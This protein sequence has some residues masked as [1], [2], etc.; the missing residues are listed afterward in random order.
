MIRRVRTDGDVPDTGALVRRFTDDL[1]GSTALSLSTKVA[2][3]VTDAQIEARERVRTQLL[4]QET[5]NAAGPFDEADEIGK[6]LGNA[7]DD[8]FKSSKYGPKDSRLSIFRRRKD[9]KIDAELQIRQSAPKDFGEVKDLVDG[10]SEDWKTSHKAVYR[11]FTRVC[12][13][14]DA[15]DGLLKIIPSQNT[16]VAVVSGS[17]SVIVEAS[18][19]HAEIAENLTNATANL[20]ERAAVCSQLLE[21]IRDQS[22]QKQLGEIYKRLFLFILNAIEWFK[23]SSMSRFWDSFNKAVKE[24]HEE[25][26]KAINT[27]INVLIEKSGVAQLARIEEARLT[28]NIIE[29]KVDNLKEDVVPWLANIDANL[30]TLVEHRRMENPWE[31]PL[32]LLQVGKI[33]GGLLKD[34]CVS[35][36]RDLID[37]QVQETL[38]VRA[39]TPEPSPGSM[40]AITQEGDPK[41]LLLSREAAALHLENLRAFVYG[42]DGLKLAQENRTLLGDVNVVI[43]L[44]RWIEGGL[45]RSERLWIE[46]PFEFHEDTVAKAATLSVI[47]VAAKSGAPFIS[48]IC[49][50][51]RP[52]QISRSQT[53]ETAGLLSVVYSLIFQLLQFRPQHDGFALNPGVPESLDE[54]VKSWDT[55]LRML[56]SLLENT[57]AVRYCIIHGLSLLESSASMKLCKELLSVLISHSSVSKVPFSILFTTSGQSRALAESTSREER[58]VSD[59]SAKRGRGYDLNVRNA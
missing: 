41:E 57:K 17:L 26:E 47:S 21:V 13:T 33:M 1:D 5:G 55:A 29:C 40:L 25:A 22:M 6:A 11:N 23:K 4:Y 24:R 9:P 14:L 37:Q 18:V 45:E 7:A 53:P 30:A 51:P 31:N 19:T 10:I 27:C 36:I 50:K 46:F 54:S 48:Y 28:S 8:F 32:V 42:T 43:R 38:R 39:I 16:Y 12:Q 44:G 58:I 2:P 34:Q 59:A 49:T 20:C 35:S 3:I 52:V 56:T 15:H